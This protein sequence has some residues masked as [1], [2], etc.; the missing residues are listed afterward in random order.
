[1]A[2]VNPGV[3]LGTV[4]N[5]KAW[6]TG[7]VAIFSKVRKGLP[8]YTKG[9]TGWVT[10]DD[11][12]KISVQLT[13]SDVSGERFI[14]VAQ[15]CTYE[16]L[17]RMVAASLQVKPPSF[18]A[19]PWLTAFYW[20]IDWL[21]SLLGRKRSLSKIMARSLHQ[22]HQFSNDKT[23]TELGFTFEPIAV[24]IEKLGGRPI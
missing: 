12:V 16:N 17:L 19:K 6:Q 18:Y 8:F 7:S 10:V 11:V 4:P 3:I 15:N 23:I 13:Q 14:A 2:I 21:L 1:M 22:S 24:A 20:R 9:S 5:T